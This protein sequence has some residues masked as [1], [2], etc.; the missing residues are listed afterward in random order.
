M[1]I[2]I[3]LFNLFFLNINILFQKFFLN[4]KIIIFYQPNN[5]LIEIHD[6][7]I[8]KLLKFPNE[9]I[10]VIYLHSNFILKKKNII[11]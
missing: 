1:K 8:E 9:K 3:S 4:K 2:L 11:F 7:Y 5:K 10:E 6:Y